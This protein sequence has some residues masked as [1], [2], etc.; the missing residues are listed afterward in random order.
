M[1]NKNLILNVYE[2]RSLNSRLATQLLYGEKFSVLK[3]YKKHFQIKT[4]YDNYVGYIKKKN[5]H[6]KMSPTHKISVL[7]ANLYSEPNIKFKLKKKISFCSYIQVSD[8]KNNFYKFDEF[9]V[10][11]KDIMKV[12]ETIKLFNKIKIFKNIKYKWGGNSFK[13]I[14]CSALIQIFYKFN[15]LYFPRDT[16]DQVKLFKKSKNIKNLK[17]NS[18]IYWKGHVAIC[19]TNTYL[20]HAYGPKKKVIIMNIKKT[21][22]EIKEKSK[23]EIQSIN[24]EPC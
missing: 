17:K 2:G 19:L 23:L 7:K 5:Y 13:G 8:T 10:K 3:I 9:W 15:N 4:S 18:L 14:D 11:K 21:I 24:H 12:N 20:I 22:K 16:K 1:I 6:K